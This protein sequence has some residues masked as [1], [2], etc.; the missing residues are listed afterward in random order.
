MTSQC[1]Q[2]MSTTRS[3]NSRQQLVAVTATVHHSHPSLSNPDMLLLPAST[4]GLQI[5]ASHKQPN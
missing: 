4:D 5:Q 2:D 1:T 3:W